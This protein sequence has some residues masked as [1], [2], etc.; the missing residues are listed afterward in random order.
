MKRMYETVDAAKE[1]LR[2]I[3][4]GEYE[5]TAVAYIKLTRMMV[6]FPETSIADEAQE[7]RNRVIEAKK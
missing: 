7:E 3:Q 4:D 5:N 1:D 6:D 2:K